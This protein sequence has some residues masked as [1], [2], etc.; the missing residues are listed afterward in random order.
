MQN[1]P[2]KPQ[3]N[4]RVP[5]TSNIQ[6]F[7]PPH[8]SVEHPQTETQTQ[9]ETQMIA[10]LSLSDSAPKRMNAPLDVDDAA[11]PRKKVKVSLAYA[12]DLAE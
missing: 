11:R 2:C 5:A 9:D 3:N 10:S 4:L 7:Q 8:R 12:V 6:T 1:A